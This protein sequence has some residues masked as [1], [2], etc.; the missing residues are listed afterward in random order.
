MPEQLTLAPPICRLDGEVLSMGRGVMQK[1]V[2]VCIIVLIYF[3]QIH[4]QILGQQSPF[5]VN[6][7]TNVRAR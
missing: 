7:A 4:G 5:Y 1:G 6:E 2:F 3:N